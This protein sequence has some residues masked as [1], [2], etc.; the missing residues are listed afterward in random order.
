VELVAAAAEPVAAQVVPAAELLAVVAELLAVV[1][2]VV[3][4]LDSPQQPAAAAAWVAP[5]HPRR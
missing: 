3:W 1:A 2:E 4:Q 5:R